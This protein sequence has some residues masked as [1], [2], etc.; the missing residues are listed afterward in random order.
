MANIIDKFCDRTPES[1]ANLRNSMI[2]LIYKTLELTTRFY[3]PSIELN[4]RLKRCVYHRFLLGL[5]DTKK[6]FSGKGK[7]APEY[8][9]ITFNYDLALDQALFLHQA[10]IDYCL[11]DKIQEGCFPLLKLHGSMNWGTCQECGRTIPIEFNHMSPITLGREDFRLYDIGS[12]LDEHRCPSCDKPLKEPPVLVPP[13]WNKTKYNG[14]LSNVWK[15]AAQELATA[16]NIFVIGYSLPET[17]SFFR[18]LFALGTESDLS[19][20][21]DTSQ[22]VSMVVWMRPERG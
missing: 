15:K 19:P 11:S 17:D 20:E 21:K 6:M 13:T 7:P 2:T 3:N 18:Y 12:E 16:E 4:N 5:L 22:N 8:S 14:A 9:F 10:K 1:I